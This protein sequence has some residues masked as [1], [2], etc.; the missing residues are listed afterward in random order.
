MPKIKMVVPTFIAVLALSAIGAAWASAATPG[1]M[2]NETLLTG[3]AALA[4]SAA[5]HETAVLNGAGLNL[6]CGG[7]LD[8]VNGKLISPNRD[9][10]N[11]VIILGCETK[12]GGCEV[13]SS[14]STNSILS[15][16]TLAGVL[17]LAVKLTPETGTLLVTVRY[18][19]A[20]CPVAGNKPVTGKVAATMPTGQRERTD[21]E[22]NVNVTEGSGELFIAST[23][24]S[25][26]ASFAFL[27]QSH[28]TWSFL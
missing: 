5:S 12:N 22:L 23:A 25:L 1:W 21:Q 7:S 9:S 3:S 2:V 17:G 27:L 28:Q 13:P 8:L 18:S 11:I 6:E 16:A 14:I 19:G 15:E 10:A 20:L 24:A 26:K 4:T